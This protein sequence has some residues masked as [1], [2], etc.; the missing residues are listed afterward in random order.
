MSNEIVPE[1]DTE[2]SEE[3]SLVDIPDG[4]RPVA[5]LVEIESGLGVLFGNH[6]PEGLELVPF[7]LIDTA[8]RS[9]MSEVVAASFG[10]GNVVAQGVNGAMQAQGLVRLAPKQWRLSKL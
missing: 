8:T 4:A 1:S 6:V 5:T 9:A 7:T 2:P 10:A 3:T